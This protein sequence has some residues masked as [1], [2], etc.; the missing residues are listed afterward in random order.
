MQVPI[1]QRAGF[2]RIARVTSHAS[3]HQCMEASLT[4]S[5]AIW[6]REIIHWRRRCPGRSQ[7]L[8]EYF[9]ENG[10]RQKRLGGT[11]Y[12]LDIPTSKRDFPSAGRIAEFGA[13]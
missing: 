11:D 2:S 10:S 9:A 13:S 5:K 8:W 3:A 1:I 6:Q 4:I 7:L 12:V